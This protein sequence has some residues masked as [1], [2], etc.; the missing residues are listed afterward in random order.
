MLIWG[1]LMTTTHFATWIKTELRKRGWTQADLSHH[2]EVS[3]SQITRI[4]QGERGA[5]VDSLIGIARAFKMPPEIVFLEYIG[6][7][8]KPDERWVQEMV[9]KIET[10]PPNL[11]PIVEGLIESVAKSGKGE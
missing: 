3:R 6:R 8:M 1:C 2:S 4:M 9:H 7:P 10:L 11:R 5:G